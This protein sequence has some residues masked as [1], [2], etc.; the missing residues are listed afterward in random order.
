[1]F[2][3]IGLI[4]GGVSRLAQHWMELKDKDKERSHEAVMFDK[5]VAL[6]AQKQANDVELKHMDAA[7]EDSAN[8]WAAIQAAV[9]A[10]AQE[11]AAAG[12]WVAKL[13]ACVRPMVTFW[14][15]GAYS[16]AKV[17]MV[18]LAVTHDTNVTA[19][20]GTLYS[21]SDATLLS[22][23]LSFWFVDRSLRQAKLGT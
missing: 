15:L 20:I 23:I 7:A 11:A 8:E 13:S 18:Y 5:Q 17:T 19:I 22:S 4:F 10:Q 21:N 16:V 3:L 1:M 6:M 14:L 9:Q 12:G 2:E